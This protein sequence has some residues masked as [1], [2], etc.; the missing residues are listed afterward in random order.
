MAFKDIIG[1]DKAIRIL[2]GTLKRNRVPS[3]MLFSGDS[4]IGKKIAARNYA[5]TINCLQ[6]D[7]FDCC[8]KCISCKK[9]DSETHPDVSVIVPD[10]DVITIDAIRKVGEALSLK[11]YEGGEKIVIIDDAD[12]MNI[13]AANAFLKTLEEPPPDSLII[14]V[15]SNPDKLP[16]TIRS[17]CMNVRFYP[18][19]ATGC[20]EVIL[21]NAKVD[22]KNM[23]LILNLSMGRPGLAISMDLK[24]EKD[25][26]AELLNNM[27][28]GDSK[29]MWEN[30]DEIKSWLDMA[31]VFLRDM[32][33]RL[34]LGVKSQELLILPEFAKFKTQNLELKTIFNAYQEMQQV[35]SLLDFNLNKSITWNYV[36]SIIKRVV[37]HSS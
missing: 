37:A 24:E 36:S 20:K 2:T 33:L 13:N 15:S 34:K 30:K 31:I 32:A 3:A 12:V 25:R 27:A 6:L 14:L 7:G 28:G 9:I 4:G 21:K 29:E 35:K 1:Q 11:P 18:L 22:D 19:S 23:N 5:K 17:R 16:D 26:F 8:D 10:N